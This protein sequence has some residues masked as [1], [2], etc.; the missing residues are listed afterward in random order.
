LL[1]AF[2][3]SFLASL[4]AIVW[5]YLWRRFRTWRLLRRL[6]GDYACYGYAEGNAG[7]VDQARAKIEKRREN[8]FTIRIE[9]GPSPTTEPIRPDEYDREWKGSLVMQSPL[10]NEGTIAWQYIRNPYVAVP[11][12][13]FGF[14][15]CIF[16][17]D[18]GWVYLQGQRL[19][20]Y[21][22]EIL[23]PIAKEDT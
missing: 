18:K 6:P 12:T 3:T 23:K 11:E 2:A 22:I 21:G 20:G 5:L 8:T 15:R 16:N 17:V 4:A 7:L 13:E 1:I 14:K 10:F 9:H 19:H